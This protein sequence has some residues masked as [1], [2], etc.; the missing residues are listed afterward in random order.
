MTARSATPVDAPAPARRPR[1]FYGYWIA[2]AALVAWFVTVATSGTVSGV[3]LK[4][5]SD[6]LGWSRAEFFYADTIGQFLLAFA[7]VFIGVYVDRFG[8]REMMVIGTTIVGLSLFLISEVTTLWHWVLLRG[9]LYFAGAA[10]MGNIVVTVT[11]AKWFVE[12]RGLIMSIAA[13]GVPL[14]VSMGPLLLTAFVDEY[15]WRAA[16][17]AQALAVWVLLYPVAMVMRRQPEDHGWHPDGRSAEEVE[18]GGAAMAAA[19]LANS[20]TRRQALHTGALYMIILSFGLST[21]ALITLLVQTIPFLTDEGFSRSTAALMLSAYAIT[22]ALSKPPWGYLMDTREPRFVTGAGF[23]TMAVSV[24]VVMFGAQAGSVP[25]LIVG[26]LLFGLG[27]GGLVPFQEVIWASYFGRRYL[28][29]VRGVAM[30]PALILSAGG[31]IAVSVYFDQVGNYYG[32]F[33]VV[34]ALCMVGA[35]AILGARRPTLPQPAAGPGDGVE[36]P[37]EPPQ[38]PADGAPGRE[39]PPPPPTG[40]SDEDGDGVRSAAGARATESETAATPP[41]A[42][43]PTPRAPTRDYMERQ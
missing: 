27:G 13:L 8:G 18:S 11:L 10:L 15:G 38:P 19:D 20:F 39:A 24:V 21:L 43:P 16:W 33:A 25:V 9:V 32:A 6:E 34:A 36:P 23:A 3:F 30:P 14:G 26:Y 29:A 22:S 17:Q 5:M 1:I 12:R 2:A 40:R 28:G 42:T 35:L 7:G 31:P 41:A 4:P 37:A